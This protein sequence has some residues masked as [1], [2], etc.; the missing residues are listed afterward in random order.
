MRAAGHVFQINTS[1]GGVPKRAVASAE[2]GPLG[3]EGDGVN[4]PKIHGGPERAVCLWSLEKILALQ[5]EGHPIFPGAVG[6]NLTLAGLDWDTLS[7]GTVLAC[8]EV[9]RLQIASYTTPCNT[10]AP[11]FAER[12]FKRISHERHPGWSRLYAR[13]LTPG[14]I[15]PGDPVRVE[16]T[17]SKGVA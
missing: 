7:P 5:T 6:E 17:E 8:G 12:R 1:P 15:R 2:V 11:Y 9:V 3:L 16:A 10:I 4:H 13:V 14:T